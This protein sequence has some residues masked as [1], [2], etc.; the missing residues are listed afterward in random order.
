MFEGSRSHNPF[1]FDVLVCVQNGGTLGKMKSGVLKH[2]FL[3]QHFL[4]NQ[5]EKN[6]EWG[7][8]T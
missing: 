6:E 4:T 7:F 8:K 2:M 5:M 3:E 1:L